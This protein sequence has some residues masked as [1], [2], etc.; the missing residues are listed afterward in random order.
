MK[1]KII[2]IHSKVAYGYVG[3]NTTSFVFQLAG[4][5][6]ITVP[7]ILLSNRYGLPTV[8]G[9]LVPSEVFEAI[10]EGILQ[11]NILDEVATIVTGYMGSSELVELTGQFIQKI[12]QTHP[13]IV[14]VCDPVMGDKPQGLYVKQE[15]PQAIMQ[16]LVPLADVL[17]PNQFEIETML[18][19]KMH[20]YKQLVGTIEEH[21]VLQHKDILITGCRF[22]EAS[23]NILHII[24]KQDHRFDEIDIEYVPVDPPGTG[25][26]F[27]AL[28]LLWSF[29]G[30]NYRAC[31]KK[32]SKQVQRVL[33]QM[34]KENRTEFALHDLLS[35]HQLEREELATE[36]E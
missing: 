17:T 13:E 32:A 20:S 15:V 30:F 23:Q 26:L 16:H 14:Y 10:L 22:R 18:S 11:L 21:R 3:S 4:Y 29:R 27:A 12:K 34:V 33:G 35:V 31:A 25:E 2:I 24:T 7:T 1:K 8:G 9:G 6:V 5:D 28:V 36:L 19:Q